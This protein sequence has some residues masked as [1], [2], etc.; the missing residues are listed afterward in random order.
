MKWIRNLKWLFS[1]APTGITEC[2]EN[3]VCNY[4]KTGDAGVS[5]YPRVNLVIC[6]R[7]LKKALDKILIEE[8]DSQ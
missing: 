3:V 6:H 8:N 2:T 4:C 7:C 5:Y 1:K